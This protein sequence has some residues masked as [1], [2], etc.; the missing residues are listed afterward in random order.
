LGH[1]DATIHER[2]IPLGGELRDRLQQEVAATLARNGHQVA[3]G[4]SL[5]THAQ[6]EAL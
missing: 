5:L 3:T 6:M 1:L 2:R 4:I